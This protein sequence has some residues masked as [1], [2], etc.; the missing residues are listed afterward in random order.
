[1]KGR[2]HAFDLLCGICIVRMMLSHVVSACGF[3]ENDWW[4]CTYQWTFFFMSFFFLKAGYFNKTIV[5]DTRAFLLDKTR[6]LLVPYFAWGAIGNLIFFA[7]IL[8]VFP[9][10]HTNVKAL[11]VEHLWTTAGFWGNPPLWFL[12]SFYLSYVVAHILNKVQSPV[13]YRTSWGDIRLSAVWLTLCFPLLSSLLSVDKTETILCLGN[14]FMGVF[15]FE[16]GRLWRKFVDTHNERKTLAVSII[17]LAVFAAIN[18]L[19]PCTYTMS[20]NLWEGSWWL[21]TLSVVCAVCGLSG[22][23]LSI[24]TPRIPILGYI[25]EHSMV[26]FVSHYLVI[27]LYR[28]TR[29]AF[30]HTIHHQW[31]DFIIILAMCF[32]CSTLLVRFVERAPLLSGRYM[33]KKSRLWIV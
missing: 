3:E 33:K 13:L 18:V 27:M 20:N 17:L 4:Q 30:R 24:H 8:F 25:G 15:L 5:G 7:F 19:R 2:S 12:L 6:R 31:D 22:L 1:M 23:M 29:S 9:S 10:N 32:I 11:N 21:T 16:I 14:V 26:F 28:F